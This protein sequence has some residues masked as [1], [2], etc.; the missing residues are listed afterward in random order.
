MDIKRRI[1]QDLKTA[2]LAGDKTL[3]TTLRGLKSAILYAEVAIGKKEEGLSDTEL[4]NLLRKELK[5]R[6]ESADLYKQGDN[7]ERQKAELIEAEVI[8]KYLPAEITDEQLD[9]LINQA[10]QATGAASSQQMGQVIGKVKELS[11][12]SV[13]GSRIATA[14]KS[15]LG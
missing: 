12:G 11:G 15:K 6:H 4:I 1:E 9:Q 14:V 3:V 2:L 8:Q 5:K 10:I 13:D 7:E